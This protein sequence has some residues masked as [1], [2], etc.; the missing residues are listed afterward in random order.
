MGSGIYGSGSTVVPQRVGWRQ[1]LA[2]GIDHQ[3]RALQG[4]RAEQGGGAFFGEDCYRGS[5]DSLHPDVDYSKVVLLHTSDGKFRLDAPIRDY[6]EF[7]QLVRRQTRK[8]GASIHQR[9]YG[10]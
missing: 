10:F 9:I 3:Q 8:R 1:S 5:D 2:H 6:T 4:V 7:T